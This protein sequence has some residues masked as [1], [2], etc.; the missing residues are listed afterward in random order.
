MNYNTK[1]PEN[2]Q[3]AIN[4]WK[5]ENKKIKHNTIKLNNL[6]DFDSIKHMHSIIEFDSSID[7]D[8]KMSQLQYIHNLNVVNEK[9]KLENPIWAPET[10][11][12]LDINELNKIKSIRT[13]IDDFIIDEKCS[14]M[15]Y[16]A[17]LSYDLTPLTYNSEY[18][19]DKN[20]IIFINFIDNLE[21]YDYIN[22][23]V[24][25]DGNKK[26]INKNDIHTFKY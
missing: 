25:L 23:I 22:E 14:Q 8:N 9:Y 5:L 24:Y 6:D 3:K 13:R 7:V 20:K 19:I 16:T 21:E 2:I 18:K 17:Q 10:Y 4:R 12:Y 15:I 1:I 11:I 26:I